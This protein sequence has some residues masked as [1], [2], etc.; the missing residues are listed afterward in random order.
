MLCFSKSDDITITELAGETYALTLA[1]RL[2][3]RYLDPVV[4]IKGEVDY[5]DIHDAG[6]MYSPT[7]IVNITTDEVSI[8][9]KSL[10]SKEPCILIDIKPN[11]KTQKVSFEAMPTKLGIGGGYIAPA[12]FPDYASATSEQKQ[13][14]FIGRA[15]DGKVFDGIN[16][17]RGFNSI[18]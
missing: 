1:T 7:D 2:L 17:V 14:A 6:V 11:D 4:T 3:N 18:I 16:W 13:Y 5:R 8:Y 15:S 12:G 9:G 10:F